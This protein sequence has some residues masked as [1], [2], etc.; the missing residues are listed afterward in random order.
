MLVGLLALVLPLPS[1]NVTIGLEL[2]YIS[3][4]LEH[5]VLV[6]NYKDSEQTSESC[7]ENTIKIL[8]SVPVKCWN[9]FCMSF[10]LSFFKDKISAFRPEIC[11]SSDSG[12]ETIVLRATYTSFEHSESFSRVSCARRKCLRAQSGLPAKRWDVLYGRNLVEGLSYRV[13]YSRCLQTT[14]SEVAKEPPLKLWFGAKR[15]LECRKKSE[16]MH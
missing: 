14:F 1:R 7:C 4:Q 6:Y 10:W 13:E 15:S 11:V 5:E 8:V 9:G 3:C 12:A 16:L 2:S